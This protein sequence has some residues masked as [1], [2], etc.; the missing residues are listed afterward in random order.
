MYIV[1]ELIDRGYIPVKDQNGS[2]IGKTK[3]KKVE[4]ILDENIGLPIGYRINDDYNVSLGSAIKLLN[5]NELDNL[6][7]IE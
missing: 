2:V 6:K 4:T 7:T 1:K 3:I 5:D